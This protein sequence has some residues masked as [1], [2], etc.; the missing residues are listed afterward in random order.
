MALPDDG[1]EKTTIFYDLRGASGRSN[2]ESFKIC[3]NELDSMLEDVEERR[4]GLA[5]H[6]PLAV[7]VPEMI[8]KVKTRLEEAG[9]GDA[10]IPSEMTVSHL[11]SWCVANKRH[12]ILIFLDDKA[13]VSVG[14]S[15]TP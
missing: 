10:K 9:K 1:E 4:H 2:G 7:F 12:L 14:E 8:R 3:Y 13:K 15:G 11:R 5:V 6:M